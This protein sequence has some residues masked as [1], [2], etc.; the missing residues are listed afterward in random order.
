M[1]H[2]FRGN[3]DKVLANSSVELVVFSVKTVVDLQRN[4]LK[5]SA[6]LNP[7]KKISKKHYI[8]H[9]FVG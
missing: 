6:Q 1:V 9:I 7:E 8:L 2:I 5:R 4:F 3:T